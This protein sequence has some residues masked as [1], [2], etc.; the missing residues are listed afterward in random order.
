MRYWLVDSFTDTPFTGNPA[1]VVLLDAPADETW[2]QAVAA[3][4]KHSETAF[5]HGDRLRWFTPAA[6]VDLCGHATLAAAHVLGGDHVFQTRSG[7]L[8]CRVDDGWIHMDFPADPPQPCTLEVEKA[9]PGVTVQFV[10]RGVSDV[11]VRVGSAA[12]VRAVQPDLALISEWDARGVI[13]T[14]PGDKPGIDMVSRA[15]YPAV[16]VPEDPVTGS[17]HCTLAPY[18]AAHLDRTELV[19]EQASRRGGIVR[20]RHRGDRVG[21]AGRAVTVASGELHGFSN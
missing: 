15:F 18:W 17:A 12:E 11:M 19:G 3:E 20:M 2:M 5:V 6:E 1:G 13:V 9:L 21:L 7:A 10:G 16:G 8:T 14:A 4:F